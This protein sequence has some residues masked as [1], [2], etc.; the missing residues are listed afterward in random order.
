MNQEKLKHLIYTSVAMPGFVPADLRRIL[1][2]ARHANA[3]RSITGMLIYSDNSFFQV[4]EGDEATVDAL[5]TTIAADPHHKRVTMI[6]QEPIAKR[7]FSDWTMGFVEIE[8]TELTTIEGL[9]DFFGQGRS[10]ADLPVG[11]AK[12]LLSAFAAGRWRARLAESTA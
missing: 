8:A 9:N 3:Q 2:V 11:R 4:L 5:F 10:L 6:I 1:Q 12:K 7:D